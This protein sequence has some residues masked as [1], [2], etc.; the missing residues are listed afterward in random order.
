MT[1]HDWWL[2]LLAFALGIGCGVLLVLE[3]SA[4]RARRRN[5]WQPPER[6]PLEFE[7][8]HGGRSPLPFRRRRP[9]RTSL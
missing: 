1:A 7:G 8:P 6:P 5:R 9:G 4:R 3:V 2:G